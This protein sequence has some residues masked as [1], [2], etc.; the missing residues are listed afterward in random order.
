MGSTELRGGLERNR[1]GQRSVDVALTAQADGLAGD[2]RYAGRGA[3]G[4]HQL[5]GRLE[6][7]E[8]F[9]LVVGHPCG[10][11]VER[12]LGG[13]YA[14]AVER[15]VVDHELVEQVVKS[16]DRGAAKSP[17]VVQP[18]PADQVF[19]VDARAHPGLPSEEERASQ[20]PGRGADDEVERVLQA[21]LVER[22]HHPAGDD[23]AHPS[24][25][26]DKGKLGFLTPLPGPRAI[27]NPLGEQLEHRVAAGYLGLCTSGWG[28]D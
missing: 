23:T 28:H 3:E 20:C 19:V 18:L 14:L 1:L 16:D 4:S 5:L 15:L 7:P 10:D 26:D 6:V 8:H 9:W 12:N 27:R 17:A 21:E 25:L 24:A 22:R 13:E 2:D 11:G